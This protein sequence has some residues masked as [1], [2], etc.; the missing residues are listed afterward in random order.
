MPQ[1]KSVERLSLILHFVNHKPF[2]STSDLLTYLTDKDLLP[3]ER[4]LQRDLKTLRDLCGI[5]IKYNRYHNGYVIDQDSQQS[6]DHWMQVFELFNTARI[7]DETL[8][9]SSANIEYIDFDR[10]AMRMDAEILKGLLKAVIDRHVVEFKHYSY[11]REEERTMTLQ[12]HLLKQYQ[13]RW[14]V[15]G[16]L[17]DG[18]FR[19]FGIDRIKNLN[20]LPEVFKPKMKRPKEQ[21]DHVIGLVYEGEKVEEVILSFDPF[22]GNYIKSQPL[23][24]SQQILVDNENELRISIR[25]VPNYELE[26]QI[27]KQGERVKVVEPEWVRDGIKER[28]MKALERY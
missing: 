22:Q 13:N 23:H 16:C 19:S 24:A 6:F 25:V 20:I 3:T 27:L 15:F 7:I 14:Y 2:P 11:W 17:P 1:F 26:E 18:E 8:V 9:K 10:T 4:T 21:F 12:P 5:E 28:L